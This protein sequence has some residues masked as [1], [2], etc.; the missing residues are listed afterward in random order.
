[1]KATCMV[2]SSK[3]EFIYIGADYPAK[4]AKYLEQL[5]KMGWDLRLDEI[6]VSYDYGNSLG[7]KRIQ[8]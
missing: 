7:F 4:V 5:E 6:F 8:F 2:N 3:Q 1:M